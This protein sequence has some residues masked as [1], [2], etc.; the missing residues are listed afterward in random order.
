MG[1]PTGVPGS[2]QVH[3]HSCPARSASTGVHRGSAPVSV[4]GSRGWLPPVPVTRARDSIARA[5]CQAGAW[6]PP[7]ESSA[8]MTLIRRSI[9]CA[10]AAQ[11]I[12]SSRG[13]KGRLG[14]EV[15]R[16]CPVVASAISQPLGT[17]CGS[18]PSH[19]RSR[20]VCLSHAA[21]RLASTRS[22]KPRS[23]SGRSAP[24]RSAPRSRAP[25]RLAPERFAS[26]R[27]M[28]ERFA[29]ARC[30]CSG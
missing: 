23:A 12:G 17:S 2:I 20:L 11:I 29:P 13:C 5:V 4:A 9:S 8:S 21:L 19:A 15:L 1:H 7:P 14:R 10:V 30:R 6:P 26:A 18:D 28:P 27:L 3:R 24:T 22:A 25:T 16:S